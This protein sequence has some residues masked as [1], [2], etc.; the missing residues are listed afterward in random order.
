MERERGR[1][2]R[3]ECKRRLVKR[4]CVLLWM[5]FL[6]ISSI[7]AGN[8]LITLFKPCFGWKKSNGSIRKRN[9]AVG[10]DFAPLEGASHTPSSEAM[11]TKKEILLVKI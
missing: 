3:E 1:E 9:F 11:G 5:L 7:A 6:T 8:S 2:D 4:G 10:F